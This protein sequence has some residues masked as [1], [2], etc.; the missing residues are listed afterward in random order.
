VDYGIPVLRYRLLHIDAL[1]PVIKDMGR[2]LG[3][4]DDAL[5]MAGWISGYYDAI[6]DRTK[7]IPDEDRPSV[8]FMS[9]GHF[10]WTAN[11]DSAGHTRIVEAGGGISPPTWRPRCPMWTWSG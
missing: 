6:L 1:I 3:K 8:Y 5:E 9:M 2:I 7:A 10:D 4:E 11:R